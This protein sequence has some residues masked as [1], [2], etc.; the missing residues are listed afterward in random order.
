MSK[1]LYRFFMNMQ[2]IIDRP[3][4]DGLNWK[5]L[6]VVKSADYAPFGSQS[7]VGSDNKLY[8]TVM[9]RLK[10][11]NE[12]SSFMNNVFM[13]V[14]EV[15]KLH[16]QPR[17]NRCSLRKLYK[18]IKHFDFIF[19]V[20][21]LEHDLIVEDFNYGF[22]EDFIRPF[23]K[24]GFD[25]PILESIFQDLKKCD[26]PKFIDEFNCPVYLLREKVRKV[27]GLIDLP[28]YSYTAILETS[29]ENCC[30]FMFLIGRAFC[31]FLNDKV[32]NGNH[33]FLGGSYVYGPFPLV[34]EDKPYPK[35]YESYLDDREKSKKDDLDNDFSYLFPNYL[36]RNPDLD[37]SADDKEEDSNKTEPT[38]IDDDDIL[39][40]ED[41]L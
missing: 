11:K 28:S 10:T 22:S 26:S 38:L 12:I 19:Y 37:D 7:V 24:Y 36:K 16:F 9:F 35:W 27:P 34:Q 33:I 17:E 18:G 6:N 21:E 8:S 40:A 5:E 1:D 31:N 20:P 14:L 4:Y 13:V 23:L 29:T 2:T 25:M 30:D 41:I 39:S 32:R 15:M 3:D